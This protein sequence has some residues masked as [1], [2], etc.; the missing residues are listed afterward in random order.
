MLIGDAGDVG[1][2]ISFRVKKAEAGVWLT[3]T[4]NP[5]N[6]TFARYDLQVVNLFA[7][8][9]PAIDFSPESFSFTATEG[10]VTPPNQTL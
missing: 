6:L 1:K 7:F 10:E 4:A 8:T 3:A 2:P 9:A 5:A